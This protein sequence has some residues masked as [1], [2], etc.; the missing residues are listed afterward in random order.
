MCVFMVE[1]R[2]GQLFS[3]CN[4]HLLSDLLAVIECNST[5]VNMRQM[6]WWHD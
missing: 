2:E 3:I 5:V 1:T 4:P 6:P